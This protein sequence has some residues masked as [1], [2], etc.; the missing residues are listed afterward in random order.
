MIKGFIFLLIAITS[1]IS[2]FSR[3]NP[4]SLVRFSDLKYHS[5][6][7]KEALSNFVLHNKD[8][9]NLFLAIDE[10]MCNE[11]ASNYNESY[12][13]IIEILSHKKINEKKINKKIKIAY[14]DVHARFLNK[15]I[16]IEYYPALFENGNYNCVTASMLYALV[17]DQIAVPY[18]VM[19]S[20]N[21]VYLVAN[22]GPKSV[23]IETTNPGF[24]KAIFTGEFK[25]QYVSHLRESKLISQDEYKSKSTE[26]IFEANFKEVQEASFSSLPGFQYYNKAVF[27][28]QDNRFKEAYELCQKAFFFFPDSQVKTLLYNCL[29]FQ[30]EKCRFSKVSDIDYL[31]QLSRFENT[32]LNLIL[33][34]LSNIISHYMQFTDK[35]DFCDSLYHRLISQIK[36]E[37]MADEV[38]FSYY[39]QMAYHQQFNSNAEYY[40]GKALMIKDNHKG[41][42]QIL[43]NCIHK[44]ISELDDPK[45]LMDTIDHLELRY[46]NEL[47]NPVIHEYRLLTYLRLA[48]TFFGEGKSQI[49]DEYLALFEE[50]C[51]VP[52]TNEFLISQIDASYSTAAAYYFNRNYKTRARNIVQRGLKYAPDS[53]ILN[54]IRY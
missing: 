16:D 8:T 52:L 43:V 4:D 44:K 54:S 45:I 1:Y 53:R 26:E 2:A 15:Y 29:L 46:K 19:A 49:A 47:I 23:V 51:E 38:S 28:A 30:I 41:A 24:E 35:E 33:G 31:A 20:S 36:D 37:E 32:E 7:E 25:Q 14:S 39:M 5:D 50:S 18:K 34:V 6:F 42:N 40:A 10:N 11:I 21:H 17:Y 3:I 13:E 27:M 12:K 9:F 22:P 48:R